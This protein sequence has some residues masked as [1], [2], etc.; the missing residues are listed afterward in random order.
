[1]DSD[2]LRMLGLGLKENGNVELD[3]SV[4]KG[5]KKMP[6]DIFD[7][8]Y[9]GE[10]KPEAL[11]LCIDIRNFSNFLCKH[12]EQ[13]VF[14]MLTSFTSNFLSGV[15]QSGENCSY[16][17]LLGDGAFVIWDNADELA[18]EEALMIF[19]T[20]LAFAKEEFFT[21]YSDLGLGGALVQEVIY[22]YEISAEMSSLKY[23]D[24][25]GYG[26]NLA[27]RLQGIADKDRLIV[28][29]ILANKKYF[30]TIVSKDEKLLKE[31]NGLKGLKDDDKGA[32]YFYKH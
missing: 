20:Y 22:K 1:M 8:V 31:L 30:D 13:T 25:F 9:L 26:I 4:L 7:N 5:L 3:A 29:K 19:N 32:V 24:Y 27:C 11:I 16:Y 21:E 28:N 23:R 10:M 12:T 15:N 6:V 17:K 14:D 2:D 18:V